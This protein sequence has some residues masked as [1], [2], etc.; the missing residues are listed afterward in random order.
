MIFDPEKDFG[1]LKYK[2]FACKK[3]LLV[4]IKALREYYVLISTLGDI[5]RIDLDKLVRYA[6]VLYDKKSPLIKQLT[7][8]AQRKQEAALVAGYDLV[9]D[10]DRIQKLYDFLDE[11]L[12]LLVMEFL[13]EQNDMYWSLIVMNE[14]TFYENQKTILTKLTVVRDDKQRVDAMNAKGKLLEECHI[15]AERT[16]G[17]YQK[18]Y[19]DGQIL[20]AAKQKN[21]KPEAIAK[22]GS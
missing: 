5:K 19:G 14:Q 20:V 2:V 1:D 18:V 7:N 9:K 15:I 21:F 3:D 4:N 8:V 10:A 16:E 12:R 6:F 13:R 17:Y 11:D 22:R